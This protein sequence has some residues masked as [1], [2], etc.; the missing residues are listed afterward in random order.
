M[1]SFFFFVCVYVCRTSTDIADAA[2]SC[3]RL[4]LALAPGTRTNHSFQGLVNCK[5]SRSEGIANLFE[6][7][8]ITLPW[9]LRRLSPLFI[10]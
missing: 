10:Q 3:D 1:L 9:V 8:N 2:D 7:F 5:Q 6:S 4:A